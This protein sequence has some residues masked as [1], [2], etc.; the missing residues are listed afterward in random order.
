MFALRLSLVS[1]I[2]ASIASAA[3]AQSA[4][5]EIQW[6]HAMTA[7]NGE[8]VNKIAADFNAVAERL[9]GRAGLQGLLSRDDDRGDR[10]LP[11]RQRAA[12]RPGLR[13][14]HRDDDGGQGRDQAGLSADGR[15]R[16]EV[17]SEA[18]ICRP[19]PAT[20]APPTARCCRC[21]ST[22]RPR[23]STGT[24]TPSRRPGSIRR[25]RRK[26]WPE[27]V[28]RRQEAARRRVAVRLHRRL[29]H[30]DADRAVQR[31]AQL[32]IGTKANGLD[33]LDT[34]LEFNNADRG[35]AH[36]RPRRGAEGQELRLRRPHQRAGGQVPQRRMR[37]DPD[38]VGLLRQ[39][40]DR[41]PSSPSA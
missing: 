10:R 16:R 35:Q 37:H 1:A 26:T 8:R 19:S 34:E 27:T 30:L 23:S 28:R 33:G 36:R 13:G 17:R 40:Q 5:I 15:C 9:Q 6:W 29:D 4:P 32:P 12:H 24:R 18:P 20:T 25:S 31:L 11:R 3:F 2:A 21:R 22:A 7:V 14:R 39:C 41:T 38:L